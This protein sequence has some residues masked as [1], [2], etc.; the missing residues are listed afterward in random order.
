MS[1][2]IILEYLSGNRKIDTALYYK[3]SRYVLIPYFKDGSDNN[4]VSSRDK[5]MF[6]SLSELKAFCDR[7]NIDYEEV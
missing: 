3:V 2:G 4:L 1:D 7:L 5:L 6:N